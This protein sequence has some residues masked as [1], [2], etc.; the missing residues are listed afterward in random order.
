[1]CRPESV[2]QLSAVAMP[3]SRN[4]ARYIAATKRQNHLLNCQDRRLVEEVDWAKEQ[5]GV[6]QP[7][8]E[9]LVARLPPQGGPVKLV[10]PLILGRQVCPGLEQDPGPGTE[11]P[12]AKRARRG[13]LAVPTVPRRSARLRGSTPSRAVGA[14]RLLLVCPRGY[15]LE[16]VALATGRRR[17]RP[18]ASA[19]TTTG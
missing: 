14:N 10:E 18:A 5:E 11:S 15:M 3:P 16:A 17:T 2:P 6:L 7:L 9:K 12:C 8:I 19:A 1:M 13:H 4:D